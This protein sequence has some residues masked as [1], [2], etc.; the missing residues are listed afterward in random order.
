MRLHLSTCIMSPLGPWDIDGPFTKCTAL[1]NNIK[2]YIFFKQRS[3]FFM[4]VCPYVRPSVCPKV[5]VKI[6]V[7]QKHCFIQLILCNT[8][9]YCSVFY[10]Y[11]RILLQKYFYIMSFSYMACLV[12]NQG[13]KSLFQN[14]F[15][16]HFQNVDFSF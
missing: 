9:Y 12:E 4:I 11:H 2:H 5:I 6:L 13:K 14:K 10:I 15:F 16:K 8:R 7:T 3:T 1:S